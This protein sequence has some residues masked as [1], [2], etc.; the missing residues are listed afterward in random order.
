MKSI[1]FWLLTISAVVGGTI[2]G[3]PMLIRLWNGGNLFPIESM[4]SLFI[5]VFTL[6]AT[7]F[8]AI[9]IYVLQ[10]KASQK[11][12][13]KQEIGAK[14]LLYAELSNGLEAMT[15]F[16]Q[17]GSVNNVGG[18]ISELMVAYLPYIQDC[19]E[20][21]QIHHIF[22][23]ADVMTTASKI[24][25]AEDCNAAAEYIQGELSLFVPDRFIPALQSRYASRF[26]LIDDY[27]KILSPLTRSVL[28]VLSGE[29]MPPAAENKLF[30]VAMT[31]LLEITPE[32]FS[33]V[34]DDDGELLCD[35]ILD[36]SAWNDFGIE[37]GWAKT[38][39]YIG[40]FKDGKR[41][42]QGCSYSLM[43][44]HK[45]FEGSWEDDEPKDGIQFHTVFKK[46]EKRDG[47]YDFEELFPYWDEHHLR[48]THVLDFIINRTAPNEDGAFDDLYIGDAMVT[49]HTIAVEEE[50]LRPLDQFMREEDPDAIARY[51]QYAD[52][53]SG[54]DEEWGAEAE[55]DG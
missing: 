54:D 27:R 2:T 11:A 55:D 46:V 5:A 44:H 33:K 31:P 1:I 19:L 48:P 8:I 14:R 28:E 12:E 4:A 42:G 30:S 36:S 51:E 25:V 29:A 39:R 16:P 40:E 49:E 50:D 24:T 34:Y 22:Q 45:L 10:R 47:I 26:A 21:E 52:D 37:S 20:P 35:A 17:A 32:G 18:H 43:E 3:F 7:I 53:I 13:S 15:R 9:F 38:E 41:H 23:L 6:E